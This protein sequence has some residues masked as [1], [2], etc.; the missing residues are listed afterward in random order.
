MKNYIV[1]R[2]KKFIQREFRSLSKDLNIQLQQRANISSCEYIEGHMSHVKSFTSAFEV[3]DFA[4]SKVTLD[5]LFLEFGVFSG[6]SINHI[7]S[8]VN[9]KKIIYGFDSFNGLP[10]FWRDGFEEGA[11][12]LKGRLPSVKDNVKLIE[13]WFDQS[14]PVFLKNQP[15]HTVGFLHIDCD[16]YSSTKTIFDNLSSLI[17]PNTVIVF[18]EYFNYPGWE[19]G[20]FLAFQ[21]FIDA[22]S[23]EY[24]YLAYNSC[25]EQVAIIIK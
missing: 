12:N 15:A 3:L 24:E 9:P 20:E 10:E 1:T 18:D 19:N 21:E 2:F 8:N 16:L 4:L 17:K 7:A 6:K 11:F 25:H 23:F 22:N 13:G 5:G 14:L